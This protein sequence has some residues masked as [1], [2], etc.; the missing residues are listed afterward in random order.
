MIL[1]G[2]ARGDDE[3]VRLTHAP[4]TAGTITRFP[5]LPCPLQT[6]WLRSKFRPVPHLSASREA[7][8]P[9]L[10]SDLFFIGFVLIL[11]IAA[12]LFPGGP[13]TP[14]RLRLSA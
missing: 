13:G 2:T 3:N 14:R 9:M 10:D 4:L 7:I 8:A 11:L 6:R 12:L 1:L 5:P